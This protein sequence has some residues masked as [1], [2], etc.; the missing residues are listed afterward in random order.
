MSRWERPATRMSGRHDPTPERA[1]SFQQRVIAADVAAGQCSGV[2]VMSHIINQ[3]FSHLKAG[4]IARD[5]YRRIYEATEPLAPTCAECGRQPYRVVA[6][7]VLCAACVL[8]TTRKR[9]TL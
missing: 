7:V 5:E 2:S 8:R 3:A 6:G 4:H 1:R 9:V